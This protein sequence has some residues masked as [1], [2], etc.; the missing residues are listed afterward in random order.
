MISSLVAVISFLLILWC[1]REMNT[2]EPFER[3]DGQSGIG[4]MVFSIVRALAGLVALVNLVVLILI[5]TFKR[6]SRKRYT[7]VSMGLLALPLILYLMLL[8]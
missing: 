5:W 2:T 8:N 7:I 6:N 1:T 4:I 3:Y